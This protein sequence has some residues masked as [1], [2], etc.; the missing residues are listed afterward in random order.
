[1]G[2]TAC[3]RCCGLC[4]PS[5]ASVACV[6]SMP[7]SAVGPKTVTQRGE[8]TGKGKPEPAS[9]RMVTIMSQLEAHGPA[10]A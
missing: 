7:R 1:M 8:A 3:A 2:A 9:T 6:T 4:S 10:A 5:A